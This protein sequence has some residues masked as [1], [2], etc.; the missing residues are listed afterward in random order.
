MSAHWPEIDDLIR[1]LGDVCALGD[2]EAE[3]LLS[4]A[5]IAVTKAA[6]ALSHAAMARGRS[7]GAALAQA[8]AAVEEARLALQAARKAIAASSARRRLPP[9]RLVPPAPEEGALTG[10]AEAT[11]PS[12]GRGF[13]VHYRAVAARPVVAFP[14]ACP[15]AGCDGLSEVEYP[16]SALEVTVEAGE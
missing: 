1:E 2:T 11:C 8:R 13:V 14:V 4:T 9:S 15:L 7:A 5:S 12:C 10:R 3:P 16:A 6:T